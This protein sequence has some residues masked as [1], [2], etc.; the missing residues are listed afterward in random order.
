MKPADDAQSLGWFRRALSAVFC[1]ETGVDLVMT[2]ASVAMGVA[3]FAPYNVSA[4][5]WVALVPWMM[6]VLRCSPTRRWVFSY[7]GGM[8][9]FAIAGRWIG[10]VTIPGYIGMFMTYGLSWPMASVVIRRLVDTHRWPMAYAVPIGWVSMEY[11][12][13]QTLVGFPWFHLGHSQVTNLSVIQIADLCGSYGVSFVVAMVNGMLVGILSHRWNPRFCERRERWHVVTTGLVVVATLGYGV[14][15]LN[16]T[17]TSDG[18]PIAV[19]QEDFPL[20][21]ER[22]GIPRKESMRRHA[23][24]SY[25]AATRGPALIVW[26]ETTVSVPVNDEFRNAEVEREELTLVR[27]SSER[28]YEEL[29][30]LAKRAGCP[31][32][33]GSVSKKFNPPGVYPATEKYNSAIVFGPEGTIVD[34][35]DK[36]HLVV[37]GE[38]VPFRFLCPPIY[39][40]LNEHMTPY[41]KDGFEYSLLPGK[42]TKTMTMTHGERTYRYTVNICYEDT[43]PALV[44]EAV[45]DKDGAKADFLVNISNDGW[46]GYSAELAQHLHVSVFRAI[47]HRIG[48][49]RA[50]NTGISGFIDPSGRIQALVG[51]GKYGP[52]ITGYLVRNVRIDSRRTAYSVWG[53]ALAV[54]CVIVAVIVLTPLGRKL[55]KRIDRSSKPA[56]A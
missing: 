3:L 37:F 39:W 36:I 38:F 49:A 43:I 51:D 54:T 30:R 5:A 27:P 20:T 13:S 45:I 55:Q 31:V 44:R 23:D 14:Y 15:R 6:M 53:D 10:L 40:F 7:I 32:I 28:T 21:V 18:P 8:V 35:Y 17:T 41:G 1:Y 26:P 4:L 24:L 2:L 9:F 11:L 16:E 56:N 29:S 22:G 19:I 34:R 25:R 50:V 33:V 52:G 12:R 42:A 46:F 47:E 48:I